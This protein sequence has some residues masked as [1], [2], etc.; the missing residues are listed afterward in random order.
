MI[1]KIFTYSSSLK[2]AQKYG[3]AI[4]PL[5]YTGSKVKTSTCVAVHPL[6]CRILWLNSVTDH[7]QTPK[8]IHKSVYTNLYYKASSCVPFRSV[9][10]K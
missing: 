1:Y 5:D 2:D 7:F 3:S 6:P 4:S 8:T 10:E 9:G